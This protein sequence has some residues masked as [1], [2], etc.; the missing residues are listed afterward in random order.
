VTDLSSMPYAVAAAHYF[1][2]GWSP[3]PLPYKEKSPTPDD[4]QGGSAPYVDEAQISRWLG[5]KNGKIRGGFKG[6]PEYARAGNMSFPPGNVALRLPKNVIG[7]DIDLYGGKAGA[8]TL[9]LAEERWGELPPTWMSTSRTDGSGIRYFLVPEGLKWSDVGPGIETI[10]WYHRYAIV[11]PSIHDKTGKRYY[12]IRPDGSSTGVVAGDVE[13]PSI[14]ELPSL[15]AAWVAGLT[16]GQSYNGSGDAGDIDY[17]SAQEWL[18][19]NGGGEL[20]ATMQGTL[21]KY[22]RSVRQA[23]EDGGA[24]DAARDGAWALLG[25][26]GLGHPGASKAIAKLKAVFG[27]AVGARRGQAWEAEYRRAVIKGVGKVRSELRSENG[28]DNGDAPAEDPCDMFS[29]E[30]PAKGKPSGGAGSDTFDY[31][32]DDI[33]NAE[34][35]RRSV[36]GES[37]WVAS[38][39]TWVTYDPATALWDR[40]RGNDLM[41]RHAMAVVRKMG[42]EAAYIEDA[43]SLKAFKSW[44]KTSGNLPRVKA[45]MEFARAMGGMWARAEEYDAEWT[46]L[47]VANGVL[48]LGDDVTFRPRRLEDMATLSAPVEYHESAKSALW[49]RFLRDVLPEDDTRR[50]VQKLVGMSLVGG[51]PDRAMVVGIGPTTSGKSTFVEVLAAM[52]GAYAATYNLQMFREKRDEGPRVDLLNSLP[53]RFLHTVE[54]SQETMLHVDAIKRMTGGDRLTARGMASNVYVEAV[55]A[56]TPWLMTNETP[57]IDGADAALRRRIKVAPF[58]VS[59]PVDKVDPTLKTRLCA[60]TELPG[61]LNWALEGWLLYQAEGLGEDGM[62]LEVIEATFAV[63]ESLSLLDS[64]MRD[65]CEFAAD[66]W[67]PTEDLHAAYRTWLEMNNEED[68][69]NSSVSG[70]G[71]TLSNN[72]YQKIKRTLGGSQSMGRCGVRLKKLKVS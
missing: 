62:S 19:N 14:N 25:D 15:P 24:H 47:H 7:I 3:I 72:G 23:G 65:A 2:A 26:A 31:E 61:I 69:R 49:L 57:R 66:Y 42:E 44:V 8:E 28:A 1:E 39:N 6:R 48:I 51:N 22:T 71:R 70:F 11:W 18:E 21:S 17:E 54:A 36:V 16:S 64:W 55:P 29:D 41:S 40:I 32:R 38:W 34:R 50:W 68:K 9:A 52:L 45:M 63:R 27:T 12:W 53:K 33:G 35:L 4:V 37:R 46:H 30:V 10:K 5:K 43:E 67:T 60:A 59:L 20:C 56:F 58:N 13:F